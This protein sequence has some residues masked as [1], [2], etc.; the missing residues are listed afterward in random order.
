MVAT[1]AFSARSWETA[2]PFDGTEDSLHSVTATAMVF[3]FTLG[4][5]LVLISNLLL[6]MIKRF[7]GT[8]VLISTTAEHTKAKNTSASWRG[9]HASNHRVRQSNWNNKGRRRDDG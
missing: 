8:N 2:V 5:V 7:D 3:A 1:A 9:S 4:V 6:D